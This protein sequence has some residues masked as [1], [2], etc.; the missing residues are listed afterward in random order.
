MTEHELLDFTQYLLSGLISR[1]RLAGKQKQYRSLA[2]VDQSR[3]TRTIAQQQGRTL[4]GREATREAE[5]EHIRPL[6]VEQTRHVA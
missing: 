1:M 5:G 4:V 3:Q 2:A 6:R